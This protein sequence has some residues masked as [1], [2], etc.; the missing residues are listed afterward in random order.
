[1]SKHAQEQHLQNIGPE[2]NRHNFT[3]IAHS[4]VYYIFPKM[5][6]VEKVRVGVLSLYLL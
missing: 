6:A 1:M 5:A 3:N 4:F 2:W